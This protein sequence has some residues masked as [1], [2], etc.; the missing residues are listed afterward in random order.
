M[1]WH[2]FQHGIT[3]SG[4]TSGTFCVSARMEED[5]FC[6]SWP[7]NDAFEEWDPDRHSHTLSKLRE[8][9]FSVWKL[10]P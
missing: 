7:F 3:C 2:S 5:Y 9:G 10:A 8:P 1:Q 4:V 6:F